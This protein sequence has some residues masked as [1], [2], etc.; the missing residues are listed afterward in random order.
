MNKLVKHNDEVSRSLM[1]N[2]DDYDFVS[3]PKLFDTIRKELFG[4][5][6]FLGSDFFMKNVYPKIDVIEEP[7]ETIIQAAVPGLN[8]EQITIQI[9]NDILNIKC[10]KQD[11]NEIDECGFYCY[12]ELKKTS[13]SRLIKLSKNHNK[14]NI[15]STLEKGILTIKIP[16][17]VEDKKETDKIKKIEIID[18]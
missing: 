17:L 1:K 13:S 5:D 15:T 8:K 10:D 3:L 7:K 16:K 14:E 12:R 6:D 2:F 18:K 9:E 4:N 11:Q